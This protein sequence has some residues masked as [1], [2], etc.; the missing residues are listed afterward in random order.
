[1]KNT[2]L[3][4]SESVARNIKETP[5][6]NVDTEEETSFDDL[7]IPGDYSNYDILEEEKNISKNDESWIKTKKEIRRGR[8]LLIPYS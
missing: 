2:E 7:T 4:T 3:S 8:V 6:E 1:M 5:D